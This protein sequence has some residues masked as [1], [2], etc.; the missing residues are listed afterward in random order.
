MDDTEILLSRYTCNITKQQAASNII[1]KYDLLLDDQEILTAFQKTREFIQHNRD[2]SY[3]LNRLFLMRELLIQNPNMFIAHIKAL[4][5]NFNPRHSFNLL[6]MD[7]NNIPV[8]IGI[9]NMHYDFGCNCKYYIYLLNY[10]NF[11]VSNIEMD[12]CCKLIIQQYQQ[13]KYTSSLTK[14]VKKG[15]INFLFYGKIE[16]NIINVSYIYY[17]CENE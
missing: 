2:S 1:K 11:D 7:K 5:N 15:W 16:I 13:D 17:H 10:Y 4:N 12:I 8:K 6:I 9:S 3:Y 14:A